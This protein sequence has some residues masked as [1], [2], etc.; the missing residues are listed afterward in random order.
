[1]VGDFFNILPILTCMPLLNLLI[2][3]ESYLD[4]SFI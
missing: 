3:I 4:S 2:N 1:M